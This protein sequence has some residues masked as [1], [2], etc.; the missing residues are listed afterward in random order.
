ME[1]GIHGS[2][3]VS[4]SKSKSYDFPGSNM[5]L[6]KLKG[7]PMGNGHDI[8]HENPMMIFPNI[9]HYQTLILCITG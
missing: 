6:R 7:H 4:S 5:N 9:N 2:K 1:I 8:N 3:H